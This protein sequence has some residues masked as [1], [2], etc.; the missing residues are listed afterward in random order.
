MEWF[1]NLFLAVC[2]LG[3]VVALIT[4]VRDSRKVTRLKRQLEELDQLES[5]QTPADAVR[6]TLDNWAEFERTVHNLKQVIVVADIVQEPLDT[7]RDAVIH[8]FS[9]GVR[10]SFVVSRSKA[11]AEMN[12]YLKIFEGLA[13]IAI[14]K[15]HLKMEVSDLVSIE[16]FED[17]WNGVPF[18]FYR[19]EDTDAPITAGTRFRT[20]AFWGDK[21]NAG[22][23]NN[24]QSLP[25][26]VAD[27][28]ATALMA[29]APQPVKT[30]LEKLEQDA[31]SEPAEMIESNGSHRLRVVDGGKA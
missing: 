26:P 2:G 22:I 14:A 8:N 23:A 12:G 20:L 1:F 31:F 17:E 11:I 10:Y 24:Y 29:G 7:L 3:V 5:S 9:R 25:S 27:A 30:L 15:H 16:S 28:L 4:L 6:L 21:W 13:T 18:V 19:I